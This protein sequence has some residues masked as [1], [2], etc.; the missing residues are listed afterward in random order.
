LLEELRVSNQRL[1]EKNTILEEDKSK[2]LK[3]GENRYL[4]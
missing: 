1:E 2:T 4:A 3:E